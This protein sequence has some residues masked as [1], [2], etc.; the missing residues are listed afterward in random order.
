[1]NSIFQKLF[2][3]SFGFLLMLN[4]AESVIAQT[5]NSLPVGPSPSSTWSTSGS[6]LWY[7]DSLYLNGSSAS[8]TAY[9]N[10]NAGQSVTFSF[11]YNQYKYDDSARS[12]NQQSWSESSDQQGGFKAYVDGKSVFV[13]KNPSGT[14]S[15][16]F[17]GTGRDSVAFMGGNDRS[18]DEKYN[19]SQ[20]S[21]MSVSQGGAPEIDGS[22]AP[23]VGFLL[24][25]LFLMFGSRK[26]DLSSSSE[27]SNP[28]I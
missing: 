9:F 12:I 19:V 24:G 1:M 10:D 14:Y 20:I 26:K 2:H 13:A 25:C 23:K 18:N 27:G 8:S 3:F 11:N 16:T 21:S 4:G 7:A 22:L 15:Y 5:Y 17:T 28:S 6:A